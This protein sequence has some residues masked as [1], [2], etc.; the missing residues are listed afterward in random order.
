MLPGYAASGWP[1]FRLRAATQIPSQ[2]MPL[3]LTLAL[4]LQLPAAQANVR[5]GA[6]GAPLGRML[7]GRTVCLY[8]LGATARALAH[9]LRPMG[10]RLIGITRDPTAPKTAEFPLDEWLQFK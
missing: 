5:Q 10:V 3:L 4:L 2:S 8:G 6:L 7:A 1:M 9:R